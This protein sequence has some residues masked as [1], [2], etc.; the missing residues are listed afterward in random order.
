MPKS[1]QTEAGF[2]IELTLNSTHRKRDASNSTK[3]LS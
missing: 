1:I 2:Y 3:I